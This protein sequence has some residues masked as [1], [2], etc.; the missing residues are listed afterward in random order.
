MTYE[1]IVVLMTAMRLAKRFVSI[2]IVTKRTATKTLSTLA[3]LTIGQSILEKLFYF[4]IKV[5]KKG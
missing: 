4:Q 1:K 2:I 5:K 3:Y